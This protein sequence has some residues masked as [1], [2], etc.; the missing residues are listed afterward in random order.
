MQPDDIEIRIDLDQMYIDDL[1]TLQKFQS[2]GFAAEEFLDLLDRVVEGGVRG[3]KLP[4]RLLR[5]IGQK[6]RAALQEAANPT[7]VSGEN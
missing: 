2:G 1:E 4:F 5:E 7:D 6:L 3:K